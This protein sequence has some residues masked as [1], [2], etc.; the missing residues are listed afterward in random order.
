MATPNLTKINEVVQAPRATNATIN[1]RLTSK[2]LETLDD[3][4]TRF[5]EPLSEEDKHLLYSLL[6]GISFSLREKNTF[7][8]ELLNAGDKQ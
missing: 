1:Q 2:Q 3:I 4:L 8:V 6:S 7:S 5:F